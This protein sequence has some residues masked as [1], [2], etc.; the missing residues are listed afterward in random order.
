MLLAL[1]GAPPAARA[2]QSAETPAP[3]APAAKP[4][5]RTL[6]ILEFRVEGVTK[7]TAIDL[8]T[9]LDPFLGPGRTL[10]DVEK[11]RSALEKAYLDRGY[12]TV[13]VAIPQQTVRQ[14]VVTLRVTE[15]KVGQLRVRGTQ[16]FSPFAIRKQAP[17]MAEG[18]V[19]NFN[20]IVEDIQALNQLPDRRVTP[21]IRA[22]AIPGTVDI[23]LDVKETLPLHGSAEVNNRYSVNTT[24]TRINGALHYDNLWQLGHSLGVSFQIA[25]ERP[26]DA[27]V[28]GANYLARFPGA[29]W[30]TL[31]Y[32][33][34]IQDSDV[35][36]LGGT[37]VSGRGRIFGTRA[38][39][40][41]PGNPGVFHSFTAG[42]DYKL[43]LEG[44]RFGSDATNTPVHYWPV[45]VQYG[46][47][48]LGK[49]A[50]TQLGVSAIFNIRGLSSTDAEFDAK[51]YKA[52]SS[53][54]YFRGELSRTDDLPAGFQTF[55]R[56]SGQY[57]GTPLVGPEQFTAGGVDSVRGYLEVE[58][59]GD[60]G[61]LGTFEVR[62]PS[63]G[64][65]LGPTVDDWR[66]HV[67]T[68]G[69]R[70]WI[71]DPLPEQ[72]VYATLWGVGGGTRLRILNHLSATFDIG[73]PLIAAGSTP[74]YQPRFHFRVT[75]D[76]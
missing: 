9:A 71:H 69:G 24:H 27:K 50:Q 44:V 32:N 36:T 2:G 51:R 10:E 64:V 66:F 22:G 11:A 20:D 33:V 39:F 62:S 3:P 60:Y 26:S 21:Q 41:L 72:K 54:A 12:Q 76:F 6:D 17:S 74:K 13:L 38:V 52:S 53:F 4:P 55:L 57:C 1:A 35:S 43:F 31:S 14:G 65:W 42:L 7:L 68:E 25:P 30:F 37:A 29:P 34:V 19:P 58:A 5:P 49:A 18:T 70:V 46:A 75:G 40:K 8:E 16:Y 15:G 61:A 56:G 67:F 73:V 45:T 23:D 59:V 28:F 63:L 48:W 47:T